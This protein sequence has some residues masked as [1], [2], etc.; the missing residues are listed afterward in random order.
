[1]KTRDEI[2]QELRQIAPELEQ[3]LEQQAFLLPDD[4]LSGLREEILAS[5]RYSES[6]S[7]PDVSSLVRDNSFTVPADYF[8]G[9]AASVRQKVSELESMEDPEL[10]LGTEVPFEVPAGYFDQSK[11]SIME[12]IAELAE[13]ESLE[14]ELAELSDGGFDVPAGYFEQRKSDLVSDIEV[15]AEIDSYEE[16]LNELH[17]DSFTLPADYF[18]ENADQL[19]DIPALESLRSIDGEPFKVPAGYFEKSAAEIKRKVSI[20]EGVP[21]PGK[22]K[23]VPL[24][25]QGER[26]PRR[27]RVASMYRY[28]AAAAAML[29]LFAIGTYLFQGDSVVRPGFNDQF[30]QLSDKEVNDF[31]AYLS[32]DIED[33]P[34]MAEA[35]AMIDAPAEGDIFELMGDDITPEQ[36]E[37]FLLEEELWDDSFIEGI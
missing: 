26:A 19:K 16:E 15:L 17:A 30:A 4:Y 11:S 31:W 24:P 5:V 35:I 8:A 20:D 18:A 3:L 22:A 13:I 27:G 36:M 6:T 9:L 14:Q 29:T 28:V 32:E 23:V 34:G 21:M 37:E 7:D 25:K 10:D 1:M 12:E 33:T 2:L